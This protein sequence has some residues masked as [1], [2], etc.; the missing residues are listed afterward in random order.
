MIRNIHLL[1]EID[2]EELSEE[3][4][5]S[6]DLNVWHRQMVLAKQEKQIKKLQKELED[7]EY[8]NLGTI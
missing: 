1:T 4:G 6:V 3:L 2:D 8:K 7:E 5:L